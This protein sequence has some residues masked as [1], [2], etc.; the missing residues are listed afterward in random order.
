MISLIRFWLRRQE[1]SGSGT[2][3]RV[4]N[5]I[6]KSELD[7]LEEA[8]RDVEMASDD[9]RAAFGRLKRRLS[10]YDDKTDA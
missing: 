5:M 10:Y 6:A 7:D 9:L 4:V 8:I 2:C 1:G 3:D